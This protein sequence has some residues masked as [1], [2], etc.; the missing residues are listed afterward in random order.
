[1]CEQQHCNKEGNRGAHLS[2]SWD[3]LKV[4]SGRAGATLPIAAAAFARTLGTL[5]PKCS[6]Q[7]F[8]RSPSWGA[9]ASGYVA[10]RA[11]VPAAAASRHGQ[12]SSRKQMSSAASSCGTFGSTAA[13]GTFSQSS[14]M[15]A[16]AASRTAWLF[17]CTARVLHGAGQK[18]GTGMGCT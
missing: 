10:T 11:D 12:D 13:C 15:H 18:M 3:L 8:Q 14:P 2:H 6:N 9:A 16:H 5:S 4:S 17:A 1:M 7:S